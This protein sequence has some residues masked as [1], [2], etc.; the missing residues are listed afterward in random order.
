MDENWNRRQPFMAQ[1][2][3]ILSIEK[4]VNF[5]YYGKLVVSTWIHWK[6]PIYITADFLCKMPNVNYILLELLQIR[7]RDI[8]SHTSDMFTFAV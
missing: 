3:H 7:F 1:N 5:H 8:F 2:N 4:I 6:R